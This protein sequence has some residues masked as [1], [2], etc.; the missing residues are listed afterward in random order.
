VLTLSIGPGTGGALTYVAPRGGAWSA[1]PVPLDPGATVQQVAGDGG[2][3]AAATYTLSTG[4]APGGSPPCRLALIDFDDG[5]V[6]RRQ[7][8]CD[9]HELPMSLAL[10]RTA[11]GTAIYVGLWH[12]AVHVD[13]VLIPNGGRVLAIDAQSGAVTASLLLNGLPDALFV[14]N[15]PE[16]TSRLYCAEA[17]ID[18]DEDGT[19]YQRRAGSARGWRLWGLDP[20]TLDVASEQALPYPPAG[21]TVAP[22]RS[23]AYAF[24]ESIDGQ[25]HRGLVRVDLV[26]GTAS[27]LAHVPGTTSAN[28]AVTEDRVYAPNPEGDEVWVTD[29]QGHPLKTIPVGGHPLGIALSGAQ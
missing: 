2:R 7:L 1:R 12:P 19:A 17:L 20:A 4:D 8:V 23:A 21:L 10:E 6:A 29:R 16:R 26:N 15:G 28:L 25:S 14:G 27:L 5:T 18:R 13:G 11:H 22:D 3:Y 9:S 24:V